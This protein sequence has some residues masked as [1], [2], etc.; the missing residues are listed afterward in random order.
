MYVLSCP[1]RT[2][3][4]KYVR[5]SGLHQVELPL[6]AGY[7][8]KDGRPPQQVGQAKE[9]AGLVEHHPQREG[10]A[11]TKEGRGRKEGRAR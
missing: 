9:G 8:G 11:R 4:P 6:C 7:R 10:C 3:L 1:I 2:R 5:L